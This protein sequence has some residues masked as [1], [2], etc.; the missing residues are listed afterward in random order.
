MEPIEPP[1]QAIKE[2]IPDDDPDLNWFNQERH[3]PGTEP[4]SYA[5]PVLRSL[6]EEVSSTWQPEE[7]LLD[8]GRILVPPLR[9]KG[10][11]KALPP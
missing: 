2:W 8:D 7:I 11:F 6:G 5:Q 10:D 1:W 3:S 4:K 9:S